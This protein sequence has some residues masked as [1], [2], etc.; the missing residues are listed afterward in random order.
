MQVGWGVKRIW[1]KCKPK[2]DGFMMESKGI[3][4]PMQRRNKNK[5]LRLQL[6][7]QQKIYFFCRFIWPLFQLKSIFSHPSKRPQKKKAS[8]GELNGILSKPKTTWQR[9]R[10][11]SPRRTAHDFVGKIAAPGSRRGQET[12]QTRGQTAW[13][14]SF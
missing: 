12:A 1:S 5:E 11:S 3:T 4:W 9:C 14:L 10:C 7:L 8:W 6:P 13:T 2:A